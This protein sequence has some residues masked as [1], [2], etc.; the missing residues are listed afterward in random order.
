MLRLLVL[1]TIGC[2]FVLPA[3]AQDEPPSRIQMRQGGQ[4]IVRFNQAVT[5]V[6]VGDPEVADAFPKSDKTIL[7]IGKKV[8]TSDIIVFQNDRDIYSATVSVG[9][10]QT[11]K[12]TAHAKP[13]LHQYYAYQCNPVCERIQDQFEGAPRPAPIIVEGG[14]PNVN[15]AVPPQGAPTGSR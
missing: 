4:Q 10:P 13:D 9:A 11:N 6:S 5:A 14:R 1:T 7:I 12:V 2:L 3:R 8:G 15:I